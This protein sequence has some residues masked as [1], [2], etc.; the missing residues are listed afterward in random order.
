MQR[1]D[2][3]H[4]KFSGS[5]LK[6]TWLLAAGDNMKVGCSPEDWVSRKAPQVN[7]DESDIK[8]PLHTE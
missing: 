5:I 7:L 4:F 6:N 2:T 1:K 8:R 3:V